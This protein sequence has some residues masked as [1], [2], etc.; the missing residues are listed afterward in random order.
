MSEAA[1]L[2]PFGPADVVH[3]TEVVEV[4]P[5]VNVVCC[6]TC[7]CMGPVDPDSEQTA[8]RAIELWNLRSVQAHT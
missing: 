5:R 2:C 7:G 3:A 6:H 8:E 4:Q 1:A